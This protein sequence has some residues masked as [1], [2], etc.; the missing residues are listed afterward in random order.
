MKRKRNIHPLTLR[1]SRCG[2]LWLMALALLSACGGKRSVVQSR[3]AVDSLVSLL[4][5]DTVSHWLPQPLSGKLRFKYDN[6]FLEAMCQKEKGNFDAELMLLDR[7]L[8]LNPDADEAWYEKAVALTGTGTEI[9]DSVRLQMVE[10]AVGLAPENDDYKEILAGM[11]MDKGDLP[12]AASLYEWM[13]LKSQPTSEMLYTLVDLYEKIGDYPQELRTLNRIELA[14]GKNESSTVRKSFIYMQQGDTAQ[15]YQE[16][17]DLCRKYTDDNRYRL[18]LANFYIQGSRNADAYHEIRHVLQ[19]DSAND[20]AHALLLQYYQQQHDTAGYY[21]QLDTA[22]ALGNMPGYA[23]VAAMSRVVRD[24]EQQN[25]TS[26]RFY[27]LMYGVARQPQEN[28]ELLTSCMAY[29]EAKKWPEDSIIPFV[30]LQLVQ[31]PTDITARFQLMKYLIGK[32]EV[33]ELAEVCHEGTVHNPE[34]LL[35]YYYES[36]ACYSQDKVD[37]AIEICERGLDRMEEGTSDE[38]VA[39][40]YTSLGNLYQTKGLREKTY[41]AYDKALQFDGSNMLCLNNYAYYLAQDNRELD[42]A[43]A[44]SLKT[45]E[46]EPDN[47]TYLDTYAWIMFVSK[48]YGLARTYIDKT[49]KLAEKTAENASLFEHAGDIYA[50]LGQTSRALE[51][52]RTA[53]QLTQ[54]P[55]TRR[56][57]QKKIKLRKYVAQ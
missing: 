48:N 20:M 29:L 18:L 24:Y 6:Y 45:I 32:M 34:K 5:F 43:A 16:V 1:L 17:R 54:E 47:V 33:E 4:H 57:I 52:W 31:E 23:Q 42:K 13:T 28:S 38:L 39:E 21:A 26:S 3:S 19:R 14:E 41:Q 2:L 53:L 8:S 40:V 9:P 27:D 10:R 56:L 12:K 44:M 36:L 22:I 55:D 25:I 30:R 35:F 15:A 50:K 37:E 49:I 46:A 51:Y 7:A 11:Y